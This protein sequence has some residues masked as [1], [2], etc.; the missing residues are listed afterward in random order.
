MECSMIG[1]GLFKRAVTAGYG[2]EEAGAVIKVL[3]AG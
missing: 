2:E 1:L 3:R